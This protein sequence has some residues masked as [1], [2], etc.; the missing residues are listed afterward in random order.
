MKTMLSK[1][2]YIAANA[3]SC[4][5]DKGGNPYIL[6]CLTVMQ[7]LDS[8]DEELQCIAVLH[9]TL[10]DTWITADYLRAQGFPNTVVNAVI[11][12]TKVQGQSSKDYL[13]CVMQTKETMLVKLADLAH[14]MDLS[15]L[16]KISEKD[17]KRNQKYS[18]T[19]MKISAKL[20]G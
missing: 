11:M 14:N 1:A 6:H 13:E 18:D 2:I 3:H 5:F 16:D 9:D 8:D 12:L 15:R 4:Q 7:G 19:Y 10:E 20:K 17:I